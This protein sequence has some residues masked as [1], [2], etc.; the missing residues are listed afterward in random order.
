MEPPSES[1]SNSWMTLMTVRQA[2]A[3]TRQRLGTMPAGV[4][5]LLPELSGAVRAASFAKPYGLHYVQ[6]CASLFAIPVTNAYER[7]RQ[8]GRLA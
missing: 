5:A 4:Q 7:R 1:T 8:I 6:L 3:T 2:A